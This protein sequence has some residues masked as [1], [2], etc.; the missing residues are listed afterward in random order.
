MIRESDKFYTLCDEL[1]LIVGQ[2]LLF[3]CGNYLAHDEYC[4]LVRKET[5]VQVTRII[6]NP[7]L[8]LICGGNEDVWLSGDFGWENGWREISSTGEFW[9]GYC[10]R[11]WVR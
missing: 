6:Y 8:V 5:V 9:R 7:S 4:E 1:G 11:H 10:R 3:S 2:D